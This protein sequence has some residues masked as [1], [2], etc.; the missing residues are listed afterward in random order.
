[1][2][3][4]FYISYMVSLLMMAVYF[5]VIYSYSSTESRVALV[6]EDS[7]LEWASAILWLFGGILSIVAII[8]KPIKFTGIVN[9]ISYIIPICAIAAFLDETSFMGLLAGKD[10]PVHQKLLQKNL[11]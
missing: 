3:K 4:K 7:S 1:M 10:N 2:T 8:I 11:L 9:R 6:T 5:T